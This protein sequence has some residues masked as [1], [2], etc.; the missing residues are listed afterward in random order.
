MLGLITDYQIL[1][2][3]LVMTVLS[4]F[5]RSS[6]SPITFAQRV[7]RYYLDRKDLTPATRKNFAN[8]AS[9]LPRDLYPY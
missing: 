2:L 9:R 1:L 4:F 6:T 3:S 5:L 7:Q 8:L